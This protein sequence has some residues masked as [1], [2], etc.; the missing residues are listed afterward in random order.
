MNHLCPE[1]RSNGVM[2]IEG[3]LTC[4]LAHGGS[5]EGWANK[6]SIRYVGDEFDMLIKV[7]VDESVEF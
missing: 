2:A 3:G 4:Y 7:E 1:C 6:N 5:M